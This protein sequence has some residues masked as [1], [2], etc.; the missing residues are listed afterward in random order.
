MKLLHIFTYFIS[1]FCL[2]IH[3]NGYCQDNEKDSILY[4]TAYGFRFGLDISKPII[5]SIDNNFKGIE[6][7]ADY[8]YKKNL[9]LASELGYVDATTNED[10]TTSTANGTYLKLGINYNAYENWLDMNNE[11]YVGFRYAFSLLNQ[12]LD[13]YTINTGNDYFPGNPTT[14]NSK[15]DNLF[16]HWGEFV[17]GIKVE[18]FK[19]LFLGFSGTYNVMLN[20]KQPENFKTLYVPGFNRVFE[21]NT[22]FGFNYTI[23]YLIPF[24]YK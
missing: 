18:T 14:A 24:N 1:I 2:L 13:N 9:Y 22:G 4:K 10:Y 16:A 12:T 17:F 11:L 21:T 20:L 3:N 8:R 7:V 15:S 23:S 19:N 5:S 6:F